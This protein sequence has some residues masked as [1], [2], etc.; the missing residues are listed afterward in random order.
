[1]YKRWQIKEMIR[2]KK[3]TKPKTSI[4]VFISD[5]IGFSAK[6]IKVQKCQFVTKKKL[7][8]KILKI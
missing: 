7:I 3:V 6:S 1:M 8:K 2:K 4:P 5:K